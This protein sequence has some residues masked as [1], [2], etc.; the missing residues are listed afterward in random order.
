MSDEERIILAIL[1]FIV[2]YTIA[3][4]IYLGFRIVND[5]KDII[6]RLDR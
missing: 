4:A 2:V 3:G 1:A 5:I 6:E